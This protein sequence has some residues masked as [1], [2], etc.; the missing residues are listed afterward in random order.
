[1][2]NLIVN[3][4]RS[5]YYYPFDINCERMI[6]LREFTEFIYIKC[7]VYICQRSYYNIHEQ[8]VALAG[9]SVV[10]G[11]HMSL[12]HHISMN[13]CVCL[14]RVTE[15]TYRFFLIRGMN[16]GIDRTI[17]RGGLQ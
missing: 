15:G 16:R 7:N 10:C 4:G 8:F 3:I 17:E 12:I 11:P 13:I 1:M 2:I 5:K 14:M 6:V 9:E